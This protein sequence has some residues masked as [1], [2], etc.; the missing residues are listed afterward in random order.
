V[1]DL[2]LDSSLS[3]VWYLEDEEDPYADTV[4]GALPGREALVP[5]LWPYEIANGLWVAERRGRTTATKIQ[6]VLGLLQPLPIRVD[7]ASHERARAEVLALARQAGLAVY[8][9]AYLELAI[10][11]GLPI[12]TLDAR[13]RE[14]AGRLG[15]PEFRP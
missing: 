1:S 6:R 5:S 12:A 11:E 14:A 4:L 13:L 2:V 15:V 8:D 9:A 10:R 3:L 7:V